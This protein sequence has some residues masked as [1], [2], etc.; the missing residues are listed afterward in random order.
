[1]RSSARV[2]GRSATKSRASMSAQRA[3][4]CLGVS[5]LRDRV[6]TGSAQPRSRG[7]EGAA[8]D[9]PA[10]S[11][12]RDEQLAALTS[13]SMARKVMA[14]TTLSARSSSRSCSTTTG[15]SRS[16]AR[17]TAA[18]SSSVTRRGTISAG[19]GA[20]APAAGPRPGLPAAPAD[21]AAGPRP[22]GAGPG[23]GHSGGRF[24]LEDLPAAL[25]PAAQIAAG[26]AVQAVQDQPLR[27]TASGSGPSSTL[28]A[29]RAVAA[30][31]PGS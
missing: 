26:V 2:S 16:A 8:D 6:P 3:T 12:L 5:L 25:Q 28:M 14:T 29:T 21:P 20:A 11:L 15:L 31:W 7:T 27:S 18:R 24:S 1:M 22:A 13:S 30:G 10:R 17:M 23:R 19:A 4:R 9:G